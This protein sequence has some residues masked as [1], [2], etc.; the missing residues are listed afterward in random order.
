[1]KA[2][3]V[4]ITLL[5][6]LF[7]HGLSAQNTIIVDDEHEVLEINGNNLDYLED[8]SGQ[9]TF[10]DIL[11]DEY[12][13]KF[14]HTEKNKIKN[15]QIESTYWLKVIIT[16]NSKA[17]KN[18]VVELFDFRI[19]YIEAY[20]PDHSGKYIA[21]NTGSAY[22]F[23]SKNYIHKNF[24]FDFPKALGLPQTLYFKIKADQPV[25][26]IGTVRTY[27]KF[28]E[29]STSE[30]F[31][32][33]IFYGIVV[34]MVFY[35]M[36]LFLALQDK[37]YLFYVLYVLSIGFYA[38][39]QDGLGFEFLWP[40]YPF[41][42]RYVYPVADYFMIVWALF[43][44]KSFLNTK[45]HSAKLDKG[46]WVLFSLR[47]LLF[48][49]WIYNPS[50][51]YSS[52]MDLFFLFYIY[53][54]GIIS[55]R[56]GYQMARFYVLAFTLFFAGFVITV[57]TT[58]FF[59]ESPYTVYGFNIGVLSEMIL[60]SLALADRIKVL[61]V[62]KEDAQKETITQFKANEALKDKL[63]KEL[64][65]KVIERT[66]ELDT[67]VY[68]SSHDIKGPIRSIMGV[69]MVGL[70]DITDPGSRLYFEHIR[71]SSRRLDRVV[72]Q[73]LKVMEAKSS[74]L[75][76]QQ[77]DFKKM[78]SDLLS[79]FQIFP[80]FNNLKSEIQIIQK[81]TFF[82]DATLLFFIIQN[83]IENSITHQDESKGQPFLKI[84][85]DVKNDF[86]VIKISDNGLGIEK[87]YHEKIFEMF[88]KVNLESTGSGLGLYMTKNN[89]EKLNGTIHV[90]SDPG[91]GSTFT[92]K[93]KNLS[94]INKP[95]NLN[96]SPDSL[97]QEK[98][99]FM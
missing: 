73:L 61:T 1:M 51:T 12:Q 82:S 48:L 66:S 35:N 19:N 75:E 71:K 87:E 69:A 16:N 92:V 76:S 85:I 74:S 59:R 84:S 89:L 80:G 32:L 91:V 33:A 11:S 15:D 60:L 97:N 10:N 62:E 17:G 72:C 44:A 65:E 43:Y 56:S 96:G 47:T 29:Y 57:V 25:T 99:L 93:I 94:K 21:Q 90:E 52:W 41:L 86:A 83:L 67:F 49:G 30:Y 31:Y 23:Y 34:S 26:F 18:W 70:Q 77:I 45:I 36:F 20:F 79:H 22:P 42:N 63:N 55:W 98:I 54:A 6:L 64:E 2:A 68:K 14:K 40:S 37:A 28:T 53:L 5:L 58:L 46:I 8:P 95:A 24:V 13:R 27:Q 3:I 81:E 50:L 38:L 7:S 39:S 88:F 78:V 4:Y 9:L